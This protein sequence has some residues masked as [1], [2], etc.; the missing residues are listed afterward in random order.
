MGSSD[1]RIIPHPVLDAVPPNDRDLLRYLITYVSSNPP[2]YI[3][4][5]ADSRAYLVTDEKLATR[6]PSSEAAHARLTQVIERE[7]IQEV[8]NSA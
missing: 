5:D 3:A 6:F 8:S 7:E 4:L 2:R 1:F